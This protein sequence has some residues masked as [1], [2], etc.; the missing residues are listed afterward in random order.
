MGRISLLLPFLALVFLPAQ[1]QNDPF[2]TFA[3]PLAEGGTVEDPFANG[4]KVFSF[5]LADYDNDG[6]L[7][8]LAHG[9]DL[10]PGFPGTYFL[11]IYR[12]DGADDTG[13]PVFTRLPFPSEDEA[14]DIGGQEAQIEW[15]DYDNDGDLDVLVAALRYMPDGS[16]DT[17]LPTRIYLNED[18]VFSRADEGQLPA[19]EVLSRRYFSD[20]SVM[21]W[22]DYDNDGDPDL[23]VPGAFDPFEAGGS[24]SPRSK[25][26]RNDEGTLV[27]TDQDLPTQ[28]PGPT[29]WGDYDNDGD[30]DLLITTPGPEFPG[31]NTDTT[32]VMRNDGGELT[33]TDF[34]VNDYEAGSVDWADYDNDGDLDILMAGR[35]AKQ[36][37]VGDLRLYRN[38][39]S[40]FV[41]TDLPGTPTEALANARWADIDGDGDV[42]AVV[43]TT[44]NI[45]NTFRVLLNEGGSFTDLGV[46]LSAPSGNDFLAYHFA[47]YDNDG[48]LDIFASGAFAVPLQGGGTCNNCQ[49][50][51]L[52]YRNDLS[53]SNAAPGE[54][55]GLSASVDG[56]EATLTWAAATDD[57]TPSAA[58]TY[59][60]HVSSRMGSDI[61]SPMSRQNG[62][63]MLPRPGNVSLNT[64]WTVRDLPDGEYDWR[65]QAV[66]N[67]FNGGA[68]AEGGTFTVGQATDTEDEGALPTVFQAHGVYPN[69]ARDGV[70]LSLDL[71]NA[72]DVRVALYDVLGREVASA[73]VRALEAGA[74]Q[75]VSLDL[76]A[77]PSGVYLWR[78]E[79]AL[80]GG[81]ERASGRLTVVR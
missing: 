13:A 69:P 38:D 30:L 65:V 29:S 42:D 53:E 3:L 14:P 76:S 5:A 8:V 59:N 54:P 36:Y 56:D 26:F 22:G 77:L 57:H 72:A 71:P 46:S 62:Q 48:D 27:E 7:D 51:F 19:V 74:S 43:T 11:D 12:N 40:T 34:V 4:E 60:L 16:F 61:V 28:G 15:V 44:F 55:G 18:G 81:T 63:R 37:G 24:L 68:F 9:R 67:A 49:Q 58:L 52:L 39:D 31:V 50:K 1:A 20:E 66:D 10:R 47:D 33:Q 25:L 23:V 2:T 6:D 73:P 21:S 17:F 78:A 70:S 32:F 45:G 64:A 75:D 35:L 41:E 79:A 80:P